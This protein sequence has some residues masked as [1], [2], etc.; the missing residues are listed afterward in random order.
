MKSC[1]PLLAVFHLVQRVFEVNG[2]KSAASP[3]FRGLDIF[4]QIILVCKITF[5][6]QQVVAISGLG[7]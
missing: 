6:I 3:S 1:R 7:G 4:K 2:L 5:V